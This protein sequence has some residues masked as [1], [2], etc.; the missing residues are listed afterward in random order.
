[1]RRGEYVSA[2]LALGEFMKQTM[3]MVYLLNRKYPPYEKWM[4][5]GI[6]TMPILPQIYGILIALTD[7]PNQ[8]EAWQNLTEEEADGINGKDQTALTIEVVC[9]WFPRKCTR[10]I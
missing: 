5:Q 9:S 7:M 2:R 4:H 3:Q 6:K 10:G 8:K 1:M